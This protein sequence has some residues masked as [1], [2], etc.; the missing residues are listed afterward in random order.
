[1]YIHMCVCV[2]IYIQPNPQTLYLAHALVAFHEA[3]RLQRPPHAD[4]L[5]RRGGLA[6][7]L[8]FKAHG[9]FCI[10]HLYA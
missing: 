5:P 7:R 4:H 6:S 1:M 9:R 10:T 8:V 2:Y 3:K